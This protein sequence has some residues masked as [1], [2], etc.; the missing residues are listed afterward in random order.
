MDSETVTMGAMS[1]II[2]ILVQT[3]LQKVLEYRNDLRIKLRK[4]Y[5]L[6]SKFNVSMSQIFF[7]A[8]LPSNCD[9][10]HFECKNSRCIHGYLLCDGTNNCG[11]NSDETYGCNGL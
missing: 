10:S 4:F 8:P 9:S 2:A 1:L 6:I 7:L 3:L 11:D 5:L